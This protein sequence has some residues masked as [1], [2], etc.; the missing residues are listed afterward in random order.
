MLFTLNC[1]GRLFTKERPFVMGILNVT[2]DSFYTK[3][4]N[5]SVQEHIDKAGEM[6]EQGAAILDIGGMSTR[7]GAEVITEE[8]EQD[9]VLPV[10]EGVHKHFPDSFI[11][12]DTYRASVARN[13]VRSGACIVNDISAGEM[14]DEMLSAVAMLNVPYIVTH[15]Q[16]TP[17]TMQQKPEYGD[18]S[19]EVLDYFILKIKQCGEAGI[20]DIIL[21]PGFG[22]GKTIAHN[23][24]LLK[25][26]HVFNIL[27]RPILAGIS[28]KSMVHKPLNSDAEHALNGTT[29]LHVLALQ[30]GASILR[31][32]DVKEARECIELFCYYQTI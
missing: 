22:F 18:I 24:S 29:A 4:R 21:D 32:H 10:I 26:L 13:A 11:S 8:T 12:V 3:G 17:E 6:L 15:M 20:K 28:R 5:N 23:Y 27:K 7:P 16:G 31:V 19:A 30:Q 2:P 9:R 14:D 25:N 1:N